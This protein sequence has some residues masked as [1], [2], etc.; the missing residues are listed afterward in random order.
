[1]REQ[2]HWGHIPPEEL[3]VPQRDGGTLVQGKRVLPVSECYRTF[4]EMHQVVSL[5]CRTARFKLDLLKFT[6]GNLRFIAK[7]YD[8]LYTYA[9]VLSEAMFNYLMEN[10]LLYPI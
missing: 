3:A 5:Y 2:K 1:M 9:E 6:R 10:G 4:L 7:T 8:H